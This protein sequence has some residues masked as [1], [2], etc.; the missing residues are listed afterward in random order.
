[1]KIFQ[2]IVV[3][4]KNKKTARVRVERIVSH[5]VYMKRMKM[6]KEY[7]VHDENSVAKVGDMVKFAS[8]KPYS[9]LKKWALV[10][11]KSEAKKE[12]KPEVKKAPKKATP[13]KK[14]AKS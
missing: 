1:M 14:E 8:S 6:H 7:L 10:L 4:T 5:P 13:K 3:S 11:E 12:V 9:K 2:G